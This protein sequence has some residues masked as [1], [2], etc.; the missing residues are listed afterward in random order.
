MGKP[1]PTGRLKRDAV[2]KVLM[3]LPVL[4]EC[5]FEDLRGLADVDT[6]ARGYEFRIVRKQDLERHG[7]VDD[8]AFYDHWLI[9]T[10]DGRI[11]CRDRWGV[12]FEFTQIRDLREFLDG[13]LFDRPDISSA[14]LVHECMQ[15]LSA[16]VDQLE[17]YSW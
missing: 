13:N 7:T 10:E 11:R 4:K 1:I 5:E 3:D 6:V 17:K 15:M 8:R 12:K 16:R 2:R 9:K 14:G